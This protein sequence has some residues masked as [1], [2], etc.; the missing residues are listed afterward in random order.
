MR[1]EEAGNKQ[2]LINDKQNVQIESKQSE[3]EKSFIST[4]K[5]AHLYFCLKKFCS[6]I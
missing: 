1:G 6:E 3:T 5:Y 4:N 2:V